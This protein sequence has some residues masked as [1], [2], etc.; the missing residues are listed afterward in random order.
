MLGTK[1]EKAPQH[2]PILPAPAS[3]SSTN[4]Q[5]ELMGGSRKLKDSWRPPQLMLM[6]A[7][8]A[9]LCVLSCRLTFS[10]LLQST[11]CRKCGHL[12]AKH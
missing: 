6:L 2:A 8:I 4:C 3:S 9:T 10:E 5:T 12:T 7:P 11:G 1:M